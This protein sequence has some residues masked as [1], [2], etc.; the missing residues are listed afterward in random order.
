MDKEELLRIAYIKVGKAAEVLQQGATCSMRRRMSASGP[1]A[2]V[3]QPLLPLGLLLLS[4][5]IPPQR[6]QCRQILLR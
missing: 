3:D 1:K 6:M 2:D 4:E 5:L